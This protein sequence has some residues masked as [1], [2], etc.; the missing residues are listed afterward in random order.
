M[1]VCV[2]PLRPRVLIVM[3]VRLECRITVV[4]LGLWA[5]SLAAER[6]R[7]PL[8]FDLILPFHLRRASLPH[9]TFCGSILALKDAAPISDSQEN[10]SEV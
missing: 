3:A 1:V 6:V 2:E 5:C 4:R 7:P 9:P 8:P 10:L